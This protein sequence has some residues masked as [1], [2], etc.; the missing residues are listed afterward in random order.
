MGFCVAVRSLKAMR[1]ASTSGTATDTDSHAFFVYLTYL[2]PTR[3]SRRHESY[4]HEQSPAPLTR[5]IRVANPIHP[6]VS[7]WDAILR[8]PCTDAI[9]R[10]PH[11]GTILLYGI[12]VRTRIIAS[13]ASN[14]L[15]WCVPP[16]VYP[17]R[18]THT[19]IL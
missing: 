10:V 18:E 16:H 17:K 3:G 15:S 9:L 13:A 4:T 5:L 1:E 14:H 6:N 7:Y 11:D 8:P 19:V 2:L 12:P